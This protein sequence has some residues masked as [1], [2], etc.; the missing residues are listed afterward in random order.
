VAAKLISQG[1]T[2]TSNV[3]DN[4]GQVDVCVPSATDRENSNEYN[5]TLHPRAAAGSVSSVTPCQRRKRRCM[6]K[7]SYQRGT[8]E[9]HGSNWRGKVYV[10]VVGSPDR[11]A[12]WI[13][14]GTTSM[15]KREAQRKFGQ[16][17]EEMGINSPSYQI[18]SD[19]PAQTFEEVSERWEDNV[20]NGKKPKTQSTM[21]CELRKHLRPAF[22]SLSVEEITPQLVS[23]WAVKWCRSGLSVKSVKN[24]V[25]T[26]NLIRKHAGLSYFPA[27]SVT[28]PSQSEAEKEQ[29]CYMQDHV[30]AIVAAAKGWHK[31]YLAT[32]AGTGLR[33]G[34]LA[35]LRIE[36]GDVDLGKK[37]IHVR[38]SV[39]EG[40]E[41]SP[42]SRN[43]Y[44][45]LPIDGE[46]VAMLR[47]HIGDRRFG[48]VF[49][50][51][52][53]TPVRLNNILRRVLHPILKK[54]GLPKSGMHAFRHHRCSFLVEH[55]V[56]VAAIKQWLGHG[57]EQMIRRY[58]HHRPEYH[59]AI[60]AKI[61]SIFAVQNEPKPGLL[62][63]NSPKTEVERKEKIA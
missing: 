43:A 29:P 5:D 45:W 33:A 35:G 17:V 28:Y 32:A 59:G 41:Q 31:V 18:P 4:L 25:I 55:D 52:N 2:G 20:L 40:K 47:A 39:S 42:K 60:L 22:G 1:N 54:L 9:K 14:I 8:I 24:L 62:V 34:E 23:E 38:R 63:P 21:K 36:T 30:V 19:T 49:Q 44:R 56:P 7:R 12:K 46:L 61:T 57:S 11:R 37:L 6:S 3:G 50:S 10:D 58:T 16:I 15:T 51:R 53:G 27:K 48:Y 13:V 26:L